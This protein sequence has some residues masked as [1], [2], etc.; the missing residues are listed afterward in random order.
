MFENGARN[1]KGTYKYWEYGKPPN[2]Q[3]EFEGAFKENLKTGLGMMKYRGGAFY[4]GHFLEGKRHGEGT[5]KYAMATS[6][7]ECG[8]TERSMERERMSTAQ[9][10]T[11][12]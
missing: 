5:F 1:G 7:A 8:K 12:L 10:S 3:L 9:R 4:H 11:K 2:E 6:T